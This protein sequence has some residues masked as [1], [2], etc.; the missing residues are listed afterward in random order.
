MMLLP[1]SS[2]S[3]IPPGPGMMMAGQG[4]ELTGNPGKMFQED[5]PGGPGMVP[6]PGGD[7]LGDEVLDMFLKDGLPEGE[8]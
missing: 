5:A 4:G 2:G 8:F 6:G 3:E 1:Q 7:A